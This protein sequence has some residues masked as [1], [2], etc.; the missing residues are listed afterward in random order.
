MG[1]AYLIAGI[2][3]ALRTR[4]KRHAVFKRRKCRE[5]PESL[6]VVAGV[7]GLL[8]HD[9]IIIGS[10]LSIE[11]VQ[12]VLFPSRVFGIGPIVDHTSPHATT[13]PPVERWVW[14]KSNCIGRCVGTL[15]GIG[16][17]LEEVLGYLRRHTN[18]GCCEGESLA[19]LFILGALRILTLT[20]SI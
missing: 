13:F 14:E 4:Q 2:A 10:N 16:V 3:G 11:C 1:W 12:C 8:R 19:L 7:E 17:I 20:A 6:I 9:E 5:D 18:E 15:Y